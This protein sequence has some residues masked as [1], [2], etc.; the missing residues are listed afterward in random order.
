MNEEE[1]RRVAFREAGHALVAHSVEHADPVHRVTIIP[2]SIGGLGATLQLPTEDRYLMTRDGLRDRL[3]CSGRSRSAVRRARGELPSAES[4]NVYA[5]KFS[6]SGTFV[7]DGWDSCLLKMSSQ[8]THQWAK[9]FGGAGD[10]DRADLVYDH[11]GNVFFYGSFDGSMPIGDDELSASGDSNDVFLVKLTRL[12]LPL[13]SRRFGSPEAD[14]AAA[15]KSDSLGN[16]VVV[17]TVW[18]TVDFGGGALAT[19]GGADVFVARL[20]P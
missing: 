18:E 12:G 8:A 16:P 10:H 7:S 4:M 15:S 19:N 5:V 14:R 6:S 13:W 1:K 17:G 20:S 11:A 2:R 3:T 9:W